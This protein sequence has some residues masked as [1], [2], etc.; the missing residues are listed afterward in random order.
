MPFSMLGYTALCLSTCF[1]SDS[2]ASVAK[3]LRT[4]HTVWKVIGCLMCRD[5]S[6][7]QPRAP[8]P[9]FQRHVSA[10][11]QETIVPEGAGWDTA[12]GETV[13]KEGVENVSFEEPVMLTRQQRMAKMKNAL[14][15][16]GPIISRKELFDNAQKVTMILPLAADLDSRL[17]CSAR[18]CLPCLCVTMY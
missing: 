5:S 3:G 9:G 12:A 10:D 8:T 2:R 6:E 15:H 11:K 7:S 18:A 4:L 14:A 1:S 13:E 17:V 16:L